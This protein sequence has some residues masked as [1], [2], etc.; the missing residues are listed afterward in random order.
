MAENYDPKAIEDKWQERWYESDICNSEPEPGKDKFFLMFAYPG[1]SGYLHVGHMRGYTYS[2]VITRYKRMTG[3]NVLFPVGVHASGN[4]SQAFARKIERGDHDHME[5]LKANHCSEQDIE[6]LKDPAYVV[7]FLSDV[8]LNEYWRKFG[9][10]SDWRRFMTTIDP[11]YNKFIQWQFGKLNDRG[12]LIQKPYYGT[13]CMECGPVAVDASE[14]DISQGGNAEKQEYT[15]LKFRMGD[16]FLLAATLRPETV[17][18]QT[19]FWLDP[20]VNYVKAKID[21]ETWILSAEA[22]QKLS[23]QKDEI[24]IVG[25]VSG[26]ELVGK[27]VIAPVVERSI[28]ILPSKFC[29]PDVGTGLVT[30]VPSDAPY[31]WIA[32]VDL[33][34]DPAEC[35]KYHLDIDEIKA[36]EPIP[37]IK[38]KG[39]G[40]NPAVEIVE[41]LGIANQEDTRLEEATQEIYKIG[42]HTG[43]MNDN[44]GEFAGTPV[45]VAKDLVKDMM[46]EKSLADVMYDL[47]EPVICRCGEKVIVKKIPDQWFINYGNEE[48]TE[49]SK[50][51]ATQMN[52]LPQEYKDNLPGILDWF[53]ERACAR[54]G[55]WLGTTFPFDDRWIIEPI[56]DSTLYSAYYIISPYI[57]AGKIQ[58][59]QLN[60]AFFDLIFLNQGDIGTVSESTGIDKGV[61]EE[62]KKDFEYWYPLDINLG[63]KE[64]MTVHFPVF[65]MNHVAVMPYQCYPRGI[66]VNYWIQGKGGKVSKSKGGARPIPDAASLYTVDGLRLYYSHI[67][68]PFVD[69]EWDDAKV[70]NCRQ[71]LGRIW[72]FANEL[73]EMSSDLPGKM[74]DWLETRMAGHIAKTRD[75]ME[76]F[77][78]R[79]AS[80]E[81]FFETMSD[82]RWYVR[83]GGANSQIVKKV[84]DAWIRMM[85]PFTSHMAEELFEK[86]GNKPFVSTAD[87]PDASK[88][89]T[90]ELAEI[91]ENYIRDMQADI[92]EILKV[93]GIR[94]KTVCIYTAQAWKSEV[95]RLGLELLK[96]GKI[97]MGELMKQAMASDELKSKA[98][99]ISAFAGR[100]MKDA[101]KYTA[102]DKERL[103][104]KFNEL[105]YLSSAK[106]FLEKEF[107]CEIM[108]F[109]AD[110]SQAYDPQNKK[111]V[112]FPFKPAIY[113]E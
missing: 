23:F 10:L 71:R 86:M 13:A 107:K 57:N 20:E 8:Y 43:V 59:E 91:S 82:L 58:P 100:L 2:D 63:G 102:Q 37:I 41:K 94:P 95:F 29:D 112:A 110:D 73:M 48:L 27:S 51:H 30:S 25:E 93:T 53:Q 18:G 15:L 79:E 108:L 74:D 34:N 88:F 70:L 1:T 106:S 90:D 22:A 64:H 65:L 28:P 39:W 60:D 40:D 83:R 38:S 99:E 6:K 89:K 98:K 77:A 113:V 14:T 52:I 46:L 101:G 45:T 75:A 69:V 96:D 104:I 47:S 44:C 76:R 17:F 26:R 5:M 21:G 72:N 19:N 78:L 42:F 50:G 31:D 87:Y 7:K 68:N 3:Y 35:Q 67:A 24:E 55:N 97:D 80:N 11:G 66:F 105:A 54:M 109:S 49:L 32:L 4:L 103:S 81:I 56:S 85:A 12:L 84:L 111:N 9:F 16:E 33:A 92:T 36:I 61:L 62:V